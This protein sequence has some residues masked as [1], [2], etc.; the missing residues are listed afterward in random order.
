MNP[1]N[2]NNP[3]MTQMNLSYG[4]I[5]NEGKA[6]TNNPSKTIGENRRNRCINQIDYRNPDYAICQF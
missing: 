1:Q 5:G 6:N 3:Q 4:N 2:D